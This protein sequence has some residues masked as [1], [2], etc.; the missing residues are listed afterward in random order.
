MK[1]PAKNTSIKNDSA[2]RAKTNLFPGLNFGVIPALIVAVLPKCPLCLAAYLS[3]LGFVGIS[4]LQYGSWILP[5]VSFFSA[6]TLFIFFRQAKRT[7][8]YFLFFL[9]LVG[10]IFI[11]LGKFYLEYN[12]LTY[13]GAGILVISAILLS[14]AERPIRCSN[15]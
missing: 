14:K 5:L 10:L 9:S 3:V 7:A 12:L 13:V 11:P 15:C 6:V 1:V 4:P 8:R 2:P